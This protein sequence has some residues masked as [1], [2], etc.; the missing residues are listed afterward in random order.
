MSK[1]TVNFYTGN[2]ID[3]QRAANKDGAI[4]YVEHHFNSCG[5]PSANY[6]TV[7]VATNASRKSK[8]WAGG[9]Y[10]KARTEFYA[11][12]SDA[13]TPVRVGGYGGRGNANLKHTAMPAILVEPLFASNPAHAKVIRSVEGRDKLARILSDSIRE[14]FPKGGLVAFSVGHKYKR[15]S[16]KDR[17][18][19]V[20]GGGTEAD[21]AEMVLVRAAEMLRG[22]G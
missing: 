13:G 11:I 16:P 21:Y 18:A 8:A 3:R 12:T 22:D 4:C 5:T 1:Y 14:M 9:Y 15:S 2:Y 19:A 6:P 7:I 10:C 20:H 17:G